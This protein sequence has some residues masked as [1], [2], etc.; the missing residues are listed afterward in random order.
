M[1]RISWPLYIAA[2][3]IS[4]FIFALGFY[5]ALLVEEHAKATM[6]EKLD[7]L[8]QNS[9]LMQLFLLTN[10]DPSF[11]PIYKEALKRSYEEV[12]TIGNELT[13]LEEVR[14]E[15]NLELKKDYFMFELKTFLLAKRVKEICS[16]DEH[17]ALY[18]YSKN[19]SECGELGKQLIN[20]RKKDPS[21][22]VF[23]FEDGINSSVVESLKAKYNVTVPS[24]IRVD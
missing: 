8:T 20:E 3:T 12:E 15:R 10:Y 13:Y 19:C 7:K 11:C 5:F 21:L 6:A 22:K 2:F 16:T 1:R 14:G 24:V 23:S 17:F 18:F 4:L 9:V